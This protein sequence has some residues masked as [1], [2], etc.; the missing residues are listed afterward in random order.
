M[1]MCNTPEAE[2]LHAEEGQ[3]PLQSTVEESNEPP[4]RLQTPAIREFRVGILGDLCQDAPKMEPK[5]L[6]RGDFQARVPDGFRGHSQPSPK[7]RQ[8]GLQLGIRQRSGLVHRAQSL[9]DLWKKSSG[10]QGIAPDLAQA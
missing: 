10:A 4:A 9:E 5:R 1:Q 6:T 8:K 2:D 7:S 3:E